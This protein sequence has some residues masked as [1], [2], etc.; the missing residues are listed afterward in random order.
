MI[1]RRWV[2]LHFSTA[3]HAWIDL[4]FNLLRDQV[5][6]FLNPSRPKCLAQSY[7]VHIVERHCQRDIVG[8]QVV[9]KEAR[10]TM[11]DQCLPKPFTRVVGIEVSDG[12]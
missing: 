3:K 12:L 10:Q 4:Q 8:V 2:V 7:R 1:S 6:P 9:L 11:D 5:S